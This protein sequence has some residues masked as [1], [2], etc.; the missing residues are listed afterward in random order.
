MPARLG[1]ATLS[2]PLIGRKMVRSAFDKGGENMFHR[3]TGALLIVAGISMGAIGVMGWMRTD[4]MV[5]IF[6]ELSAAGALHGAT[7]NSELWSSHWRLE[8]L[9]LTAIGSLTA[10]AGVVVLR[11]KRMGYLVAFGIFMF[12]GTYP[13]VLRICGYARYKWEGGSIHSGLPF[14]AVALAALLVYM[15]MVRSQRTKRV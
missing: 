14:F 1:Q 7:F 4:A 13:L 12:A 8:N 3:I 11:K 5:R 9:I 10:S 6:T 15:G 2:P